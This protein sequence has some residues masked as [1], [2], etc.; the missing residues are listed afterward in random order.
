MATTLVKLHVTK[1]SIIHCKVHYSF[2]HIL[3]IYI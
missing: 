2:T 1:Y 3:L